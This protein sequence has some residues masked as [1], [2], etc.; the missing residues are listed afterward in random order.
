MLDPHEISISCDHENDK[1]IIT[2]L[3]SKMNYYL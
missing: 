3:E 2:W 1:N